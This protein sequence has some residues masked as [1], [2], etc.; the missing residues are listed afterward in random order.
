MMPV[1]DI[2]PPNFVLCVLVMA[3]VITLMFALTYLPWYM[4]DRKEKKEKAAA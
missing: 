4:K 3:A 1:L 2:L